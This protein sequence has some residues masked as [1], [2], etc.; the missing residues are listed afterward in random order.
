MIRLSTAIR[1]LL[2]HHP[3]QFSDVN[4]IPLLEYA[5]LSAS[6]QEFAEECP[7]AN[8]HGL[9][10]G[11][12]R[13]KTMQRCWIMMISFVWFMLGLSF[14]LIIER[15]SSTSSS[16]INLP[17]IN[18]TIGGDSPI[19]GSLHGDS[20]L[21][22]PAQ[23][24]TVSPPVAEYNIAPAN[25]I[26]TPL[27]IPFTRNN[28]MLRQTVLGYIAA[29][30]PPS[31]VIIIENTGVLDANSRAQLSVENPFFLDH[32]LFRNRYGVSI[33]QTPVLL[34][35]AQLQNYML[36]IA[37][38]RN[39]RYFFWSPMDVGILSKEDAIPYKSFYQSVTDILLQ[40]M[41]EFETG[42]KRWSAKFFNFDYLS[43]VRLL[44]PC[45]C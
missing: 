28:A 22:F 17:T 6:D 27:F 44:K 24:I 45:Q 43:L 16:T 4:A 25:R 2:R 8:K 5:K 40:S 14:V 37:L 32:D 15:F 19:L 20:G 10:H 30:W 21:Y 3:F 35:F 1:D 11:A 12:Q 29:G 31:D 7:E 41:A 9:S 42:R 34:N 26:P 23:T 18:S 39:W 38:R 13:A 36:Q 33:L